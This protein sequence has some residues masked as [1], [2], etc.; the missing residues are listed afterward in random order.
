MT[1]SD[2]APAAEA[3]LRADWGDR[4]SWF[5]F[6]ATQ[7]ECQPVVAELDGVIVGTGV[8]TANGPVG[9]VGTIWVAPGHRGAGLGRALT[10]AVIDR[11]ESAG[12]RTLL[13]VATTEGLPLYERMGFSIQAHYL[14]LEVPSL[15][16]VPDPADGSAPTPGMTGDVVRAFLPRDIEAVAALDRAATGEDRRHALVR[17]ASPASARVLEAGGLIRGFVIRAPWGGGA[18]IAADPAD[19]LLLLDARRRAG[20][21]SGRVRAGLLGDNVAGLELLEREG[22]RHIWSAP[23]LVRG[24]ALDWRPTWI[25]GQLNHAIG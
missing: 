18:T 1:P 3:I 11:L 6:A 23:R 8:G 25:W 17:F 13:L 22:Y 20:G 14:I 2:V 21:P 10:Q 16:E 7:P 4:R 19:A 12:C 15:P 9:W 5:E 24:R